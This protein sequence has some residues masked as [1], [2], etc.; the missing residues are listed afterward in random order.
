MKPA[1]RK[2]AGRA[3]RFLWFLM[4]GASFAGAQP[5]AAP[6]AILT[7]ILSDSGVEIT[8]PG[9]E[10]TRRA[11]VGELLFPG[12]RAKGR[13]VVAECRGKGSVLWFPSPSAVYV[14]GKGIEGQADT[15]P[16]ADCRM[17]EAAPP[18]NLAHDDELTVQQLETKLAQ[19]ARGGASLTDYDAAALNGLPE[20][21]GQDAM[22]VLRRAQ[23]IE[24]RGQ[25][26]AAIDA[27][28][29]LES[30]W[31]KATWL[32]P[33]INR[34][35]IALANKLLQSPAKP[36]RGHVTPL[37]VGI[38]DY[39]HDDPDFMPLHYAHL[40]GQA[41]ADYLKQVDPQRTFDPPLL[42]QNAT[43]A[44]LR[45]QLARLRAQAGDGSTAVLFVSAHGL[46]DSRG[47]YIAAYD[48]HQRVGIDTAIPVSEILSAVS[49]FEQAYVFVDACRAARSA[50]PNNVNSVLSLYGHD[51]YTLVNA[52]APRAQMF[53]LMSAGPGSISEESSRFADKQGPLAQNGH[54]AF[55]YY[56]LKYLYLA[57]GAQPRRLSRGE[58]QENLRAAMKPQ[59]P[60][61]G[62]NLSVTALLD[63]L[64]RI[65]FKPEVRTR[66]YLDL[67]RAPIRLA[68]YV[69]DQEPEVPPDVLARLQTILSPGSITPAIA[70]QAIDAY[71]RLGPANRMQ[72]RGTI[73]TALENEGERLLLHYLD[74]YQLEPQR[75]EFSDARLYYTLASELA[76]GS[77]LLRARVAFNSGR[78]MLFDLQNPADQPQRANIFRAATDELFD[79]Y[80]EDPGPY[81]LNA[82]GIAYME[83]GDW[84]KAIPAF[85]DASRLA[86]QWLYPR[87]NRALC[88]MRSGK[89]RAAIQ[90][91]RNAIAEMPSAHTLH[92][93]L[94]LVY[95]QI[96][97]LKQA[98]REYQLTEKLLGSAAGSRNA[99]W[100]RLYNAQGTLAAQRGQ[101]ARARRLY[102]LA[103]GKVAGMPE[104]VHN[105][106][107]VSPPVEKEKLLAQNRGY[108]NSRIELAQIFKR[109]GRTPE[110]IAE[111]EGVLKERPD[112][113]GARLELAQLYLRN[114]GSVAERLQRAGEQM[115]KAEPAEPA[116]WKVYL[117]RAEMAQMQQ[118]KAQAKANYREARR[119]A[120]DR[121]A[122]AE[123]SASEKGRWLH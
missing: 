21:N 96:N 88:L 87:H 70:Q 13:G 14:A 32:P 89:A 122:R 15:E 103:L 123:I 119:R 108:L 117:L 92:F 31:P 60:D 115:E 47:S 45:E 61:S 114:G 3:L 104:A 110:A 42:N 43:L 118:Q 79:A 81:V 5:P 97:G 73:R 48:A 54:G 102:D 1:G 53:I 58:L 23:A 75:G 10:T 22:S 6:V 57:S 55:T 24:G 80:R 25:L 83:N 77:L 71:R 69:Q 99:D 66:T 63:P 95:Q 91:Y 109:E 28:A 107:L 84:D 39:Y 85:D 38:S 100:A 9:L 16:I 106:A 19:A 105:K 62:G 34:L 29:M 20:Y 4:I 37:V 121:A 112:F 101:K 2:A 98:E 27:Y 65:P 51:G 64:Q 18:A 82:L 113:A 8:Q 50:G 67:F 7:Q 93:N 120:P 52:S 11:A 116:F 68:A 30:L 111:Y 78:E 46:Q 59:I 90:E 76:P 33:K 35:K 72:V 36:G 56:L 86:P 17:P 74:G 94:A 12:D 49:E 40:D 44:N 26:T 41:F